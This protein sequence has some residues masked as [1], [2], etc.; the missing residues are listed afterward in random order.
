M[1]EALASDGQTAR[2][3]ESVLKETTDLSKR[4]KKVALYVAYLGAGY[5]VRACPE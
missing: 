4:K 2:R 5:A 3:A 1:A